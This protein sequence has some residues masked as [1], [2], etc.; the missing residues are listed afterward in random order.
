MAGMLSVLLC[1]FSIGIVND[2]LRE[3]ISCRPQPGQYN[4]IAEAVDR[5]EVG[6]IRLQVILEVFPIAIA[7]LYGGC[8]GKSQCHDLMGRDIT[9]VNQITCA[10]H[11]D[12]RLAAARYSKEQV[13]AIFGLYC[14]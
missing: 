4:G 9:G 1:V 11:N 10:R 13:P 6:H 14:T 7:H 8:T 2:M 5:T 12:G 3:D